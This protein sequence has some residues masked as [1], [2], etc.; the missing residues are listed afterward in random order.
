MKATDVIAFT[1]E[2]TDKRE[3]AQIRAKFMPSHVTNSGIYNLAKNKNVILFEFDE[4][5]ASE[6]GLEGL[7]RA[8]AEL[9]QQIEKDD[10]VKLTKVPQTK[11]D[12]LYGKQDK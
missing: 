2:E 9:L 5:G 7:K 12:E 8:K 11:L 1:T 10:S 6:K 3:L 4:T